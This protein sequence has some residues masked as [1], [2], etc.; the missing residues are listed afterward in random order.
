MI[1]FLLTF[2][3]LTSTLTLS[4]ADL[5]GPAYQ[6]D[7]FSESGNFYFKSIPFYN[8]D[9]TSLGKTLIIDAKSKEQLFKI[10]NYL[11]TESF[12]SNNGK[13]LVTTTYWMW[14]YSDFEKSDLVKIYFQN[15]DFISYK[16]T[17]F[18]QNLNRLPKTASH[19]LWY[20]NMFVQNDT[21]NI[22]TEEEIVVRISL[23][24]GHIVSKTT[25]S[26]FD[27]VQK[28]RK[29]VKPKT[30][31]HTKIKYPE[32]YYFPDLSDGS[33]F[34]ETLPKALNKIKIE[35]YYNSSHYILIYGIID[36]KGNCEIFLLNANKDGK[37]DKEW[38]NKVKKWVTKQKY[39]TNK[40]PENC[41]KWVFQA[42]FYL[43]AE[44]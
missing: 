43:N 22:L 39:K 20:K 16:V 24:N 41:D 1:K 29:T 44:E 38:E 7:R 11:P 2:I 10:D 36:R 31:F 5:P 26:K 14:G 17:D 32:T 23:N 18:V 4:K 8:Y 19:T 13:T 37:T 25:S 21:L 6:Y 34:Y 3:I 28:E 15:G 35:D 30:K 40:I 9:L 33:K 27:F 42:Y 12:I